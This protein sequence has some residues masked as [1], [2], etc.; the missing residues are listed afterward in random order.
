TYVVVLALPAMIGDLGV[1]IDQLQKATPIISGFL[2]GYVARMPL[3]GRLSDLYGR[4]PVLLAC[5][6]VFAAGSLTTASAQGL[7]VAVIGRTLQG[8]GGGGLVPVTL[9]MVADMWPPRRR[10]FPLGVVGAMQELGSVLGPLYG[11]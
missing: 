2:L 7:G 1:S 8:L 9:A 11:A 4:Q 10:G 5:L 6:A 3:L